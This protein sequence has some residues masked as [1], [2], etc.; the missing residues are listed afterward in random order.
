MADYSD[1]NFS[2]NITYIYGVF[3]Q[4]KLESNKINQQD[5]PELQKIDQ[6]GIK[7]RLRPSIIYEAKFEARPTFEDRPKICLGPT[8]RPKLGLGY[9]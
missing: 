3:M 1:V 5:Q 2:K 6:F 9:F 7:N 4:K 8:L